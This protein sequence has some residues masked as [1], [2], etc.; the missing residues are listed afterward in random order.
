MRE[1]NSKCGVLVVDD[2]PEILGA[3]QDLLEDEFVV[4]TA[5]DAETALR[6]LR[7][8]EMAV[9]LTD[10]R[11]PGISGD[12]FLTKARKFCSATRI[13]ITGYSDISAL[14]RAVN[15][16]QIYAYVTKPWDPANFK[17]TVARAAEHYQLTQQVQ[18][19]E[20]R[21]R[22]LFE[23]AP[24]AY[25]EIDKNASITTVNLAATT[26]LGHSQ[27]DLLGRKFWT[28][29]KPQSGLPHDLRPGDTL[30]EDVATAAIEQNFVHR[31]GHLITVELHAT[32]IRTQDGEVTGHRVAML[33]I[34]AR[35]H[36]EQTSRI[37]AMDLAMS[38][39]QLRHALERAKEA[40]AI[41][42]QFL[43]RMSHEFRTP[44]NSIIGFSQLV[45]D[46]AGGPVS[47]DQNDFLEDV[48]ASSTHLLR[49][50]N[51]LLDLETVESGKLTFSRERVNPRQCL[52]EVKDALRLQADS[53][54]ISVMLDVEPHLSS[55]M[56]D[57]VR[58]KQALYN[59]MSNAI[60]FTRDGGSVRVAVSCDDARTFRLEVSDTGVGIKPEDLPRLFSDFVQLEAT[61]KAPSQG[62]GLGLSLT[63]CIVEAQGGIVGVRSTPGQG[64]T[65]YAVLPNEEITSDQDAS[66]A[67]LSPRLA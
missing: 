51:D 33:D 43:A 57:P 67:E 38:N 44:L 45:K 30:T 60:K 2:E 49:L 25:I 28:L 12:E 41:K 15:N 58:L 39:E 11:M 50:V 54:R 52:N 35:K 26:L 4:S 63:K 17:N 56:T 9:I 59:Y 55:V 42:S 20:R 13:L 53:K 34:T 65:F 48:V 27:G 16:G 22:L 1:E 36:A 14:A 7:Q 61:R 8:T 10:Q 66:S 6:L 46:G 64:S 29:M 21:F 18:E 47:T 40:S 24:V 23:E 37:Y 31:D 5:T 19:S 3:L 62:A 32:S